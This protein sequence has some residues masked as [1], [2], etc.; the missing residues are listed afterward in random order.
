MC[1]PT[2]G[3]I[4]KFVNELNTRGIS[5]SPDAN[6][7]C[8]KITGESNES[9]L[10]IREKLFGVPPPKDFHVGWPIEATG[11]VDGV[12]FKLDETKRILDRLK[13]EDVTTTIITYHGRQYLVWEEKDDRLVRKIIGNY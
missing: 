6:P 9:I 10:R 4:E 3:N 1:F 5:N 2:E 7:D 13:T 8:V 11:I 12:E